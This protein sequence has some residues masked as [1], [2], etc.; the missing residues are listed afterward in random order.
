MLNH[1]GIL[2]GDI[3]VDFLKDLRKFN[4]QYEMHLAR[5]RLWL[6]PQNTRHNLF[7][8]KYSSLLRPVVTENYAGIAYAMRRD[9]KH[10]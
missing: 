7:Y 10:P 6:D 3:T 5:T 1:Y 8:I 4:I 9:A 2:S